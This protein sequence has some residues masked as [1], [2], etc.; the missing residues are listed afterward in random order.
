M[1]L[2]TRR[3]ISR[4]GTL[5]KPGTDTEIVCSGCPA[6]SPIGVHAT[7]AVPL[8]SERAVAPAAGPAPT[9]TVP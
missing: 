2:V 7:D 1:P 3:S 4:T 5:E 8:V 6:T 9:S